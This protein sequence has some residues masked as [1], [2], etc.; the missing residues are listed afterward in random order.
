MKGFGDFKRKAVVCV[1][2]EDELKRRLEDKKEKGHAYTLRESTLHSFQGKYN[3]G[4]S[5]DKIY[6]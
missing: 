4:I 3:V 1:P 6:N 2:N 5:N